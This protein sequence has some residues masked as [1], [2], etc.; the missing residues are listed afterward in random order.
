MRDLLRVSLFVV[1]IPLIGAC[2]SASAG[3]KA[4]ARPDLV[5]PPPPPHVVPI[6]PEPV[7]EPVAEIPGPPTAAPA[8]RPGR[9]R[10]TPSRPAE[11]KPEAKPGES[12]PDQPAAETP[13]SPATPPAPAPQL[14]PADS[15]AAEGIVRASL[16]RTKAMLETIDYRRLTNVRK[17]AYNDAKRFMQQAED[18]LKAG[19]AVFAQGVAT[20]AE[21]LV[22]ELAGK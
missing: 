13:V 15:S 6:T 18:A 10:E 3:S 19:N 7:V 20:K 12:K 4:A 22:R 17:K 16:E 2:A 1:L 14:R 9:T 8:P 21:T 11:A 5:I